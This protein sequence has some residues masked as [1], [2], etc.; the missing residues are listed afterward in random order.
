MTA[1]R[2]QLTRRGSYTD[3]ERQVLLTGVPL[4]PWSTRFGHPIAGWNRDEIAT[5]WGL[6]GDELL[7]AWEGEKYG[8]YRE[9]YGRPF[10]E[11]FLSDAS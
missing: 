7:E 9:K 4:H 2:K 3:Q 11:R 5:A 1:S 10:A 8:Y 6:L